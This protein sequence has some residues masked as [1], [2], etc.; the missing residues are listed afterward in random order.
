MTNTQTKSVYVDPS[1]KAYYEDRLFDHT[2]P[3]L[4][5]DDTLAPFIR[6]RLALEQQGIG[7]HTADRLT[8]SANKDQASDYYSMGMLENYERLRSREDVKL[9]AFVIFEPPVVDPRLYLALPEL[10]A[11]FERVYVHNTEG[12]GY[13]LSGV[14]QSKL[15][16]LYCA[17]PHKDVLTEFWN[18]EDRINRFV[19]I[20]GNHKPTSY[21]GEL[22]SKRIEALAT[23]AKFGTVDLFGRG[24]ER[25]WSR[26]SMWMPYWRHRGTIM[27]IYKGACKSKFE[28]LSKYSFALCLENMA[29]K[30]Y[31][32]E[33][34][35]DCLYSGT[36][37]L[38]VGAKD[39]ADLIPENAYIDCRKYSSWDEMHDKVMGMSKLEIRAM[40]AAGR[41]FIK[42]EGGMKYYDS[43][44]AIFHE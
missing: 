31:V 11:A 18:R 10:T 20:N 36:I 8:Q 1:S 39:I 26:S 7:L 27:S 43:L 5:R 22:Y 13:S 23:F 4:N 21:N 16:K 12:D 35:F 3:L 30:G 28:V 42:S 6:L 44:L 29:M 19:M 14:D 15:R 25:W 40:R 9:K 33:K 34:I 24:W 32:T 37:P 41:A 38:Y 17:Q 2:N